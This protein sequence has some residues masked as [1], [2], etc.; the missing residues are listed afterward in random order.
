MQ[1]SMYIY[2]IITGNQ[3]MRKVS[4]EIRICAEYYFWEETLWM[5]LDKDCMVITV[6]M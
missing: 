1:I 5:I 4:R 2:I 6:W 3:V